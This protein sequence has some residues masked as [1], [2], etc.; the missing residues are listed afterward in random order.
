MQVRNLIK[1]E[2]SDGNVVANQ[3]TYGIA[4]HNERIA[5][6]RLKKAEKATKAAFDKYGETSNYFK[7]QE[8]EEKWLE[9]WIHWEDQ[10]DNIEAAVNYDL[11]RL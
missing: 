9:V 2:D 4:C 7:A 5:W 10:K 1:F 6:A 8:R 3:N 11:E